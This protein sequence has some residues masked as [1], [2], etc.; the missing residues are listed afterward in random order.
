TFGFARTEASPTL[1]SAL[2]ILAQASVVGI[3]YVGVRSRVRDAAILFIPNCVML[4]CN[5]LETTASMPQLYNQPWASW[6][7]QFLAQ[8]L[9]WP[10]SMGAFQLVGDLEMLAVLVILVRRYARSRQD[11]ERLE[12]ELEAARAVQ[13]VLIP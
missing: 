11:E 5:V 10:F 6:M 1:S 4:A 3:L 8:I 13:K 12:S 7:R 9:T 2:S